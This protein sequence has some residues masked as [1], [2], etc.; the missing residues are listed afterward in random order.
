[1]CYNDPDFLIEPCYME[2]LMVDNKYVRG[3]F[4]GGKTAKNFIAGDWAVVQ[5]AASKEFCDG[6]TF[7]Q[8]QSGAYCFCSE[9]GQEG[10]FSC[11]CSV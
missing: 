3:H 4:I 9:E 8:A 6:K 11:V 1:M 7:N 2:D 5:S 10:S